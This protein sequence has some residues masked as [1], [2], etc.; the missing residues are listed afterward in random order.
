MF[1]GFWLEFIIF[2]LA[3]F[4]G[5]IAILPF[6]L[7]IL[8]ESQ[9]SRSLKMPLWMLLVLSFLQNAVLFAAV[10]G[11]GLITAQQIGHGAPLIEA[12]I[13]GKGLNQILISS[14]LLSLFLGVIAGFVLLIIDL[15]FLPYFP[16]K[17][18]ATALKTTQLENFTA[19]IYGGINEE[20][21]MR[22]FGLSIIAWL[23][24]KVWPTSTNLSTSIVFW[25]A[26][27]VIAIIFAIGHLPTLKK[28]LGTI[29]S[30]IL[31]RTLILNTPIGLLCGW[32]Y[33]YYGIEAAIIA[34]FSADIIYHIGGSM[35]LHFNNRHHLIS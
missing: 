17:L 12:I 33:W 30:F 28:L 22:L 14:L 24:S 4:I 23:L 32:L 1:N 31:A 34:H 10:T 9:K 18:L 5:S 20:I 15:I 8:K 6:G 13:M 7:R 11:I 25:L 26:N 35:V 27:L 21:L 16:E 19:S 2:L 3:A 29:S